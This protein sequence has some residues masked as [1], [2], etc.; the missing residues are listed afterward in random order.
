MKI[1]KIQLY[2]NLYT[3]KTNKTQTSQT[4]EAKYAGIEI[5]KSIKTIKQFVNFL[6]SK[7]LFCMGTVCA[8]AIGIKDTNKPKENSDNTK[9]KDK[10][11]NKCRY[12]KS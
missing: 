9:E 4:F 1:S 7:N 11:T 12:D 10:N 2:H 6:D 5:P 8:T 3:N